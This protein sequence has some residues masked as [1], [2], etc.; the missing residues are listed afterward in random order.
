MYG[1]FGEFDKSRIRVIRGR[2]SWYPW[3]PDNRN[4]YR[5][6]AAITGHAI[7]ETEPVKHNHGVLRCAVTQ[8]NGWAAHPCWDRAPCICERDTT[9]SEE[10]RSVADTLA[11]EEQQYKA[12]CYTTT[13]MY[14]FGSCVLIGWAICFLSCLV[15]YCA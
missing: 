14:L 8:W 4:M 6:W 15:R 1:D 5:S 10:Y 2:K 9:T 3:I 11:E 13:L 12:N 7:Y